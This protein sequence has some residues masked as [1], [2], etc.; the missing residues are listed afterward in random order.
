MVLEG[1][2][3]YDVALFACGNNQ[4]RQGGTGNNQTTWTSANP[5]HAMLHP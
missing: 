5:L 2:R 4:G 1:K 3:S